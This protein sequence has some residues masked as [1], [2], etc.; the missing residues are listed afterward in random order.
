VAA[1]IFDAGLS[2]ANQLTEIS[3]RGVSMGAVRRFI[4]DCGGHIILDLELAP[5]QHDGYCP[6]QFVITLPF[7]LFEEPFRIRVGLRE[8]PKSCFFPSQPL[9]CRHNSPIYFPIILIN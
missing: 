4:E 8:G 3:G 9:P 5:G 7:D 1:L 6:F 2:T